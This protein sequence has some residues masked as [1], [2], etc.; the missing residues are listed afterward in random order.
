MVEDS[1]RATLEVAEQ[2]ATYELGDFSV[3]DPDAD[4]LLERMS[5][6]DLRAEIYRES[7]PE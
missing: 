3:G 6:Q 7:E 2:P 1:L 5:W 4:D